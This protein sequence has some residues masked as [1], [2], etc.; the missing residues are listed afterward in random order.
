MCI[1]LNARASILLVLRQGPPA[2]AF[3]RSGF[4]SIYLLPLGPRP[5][6]RGFVLSFFC[7]ALQF[8]PFDGSFASRFLYFFSAILFDELAE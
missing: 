8:L 2:L 3:I 6:L 7:D 1:I 5:L 4:T